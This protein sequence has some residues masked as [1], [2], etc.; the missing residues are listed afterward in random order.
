MAGCTGRC[1]RCRPTTGS[2]DEMAVVRH[3]DQCVG[4]F[5]TPVNPLSFGEKVNAS[6]VIDVGGTLKAH[7]SLRRPTA[8]G[9]GRRWRIADRRRSTIGQLCSWSLRRDRR[10][11]GPDRDRRRHDEVRCSPVATEERP[12][13]QESS[14]R[15]S[16]WSG[17][18][19]RKSTASRLDVL[20]HRDGGGAALGRFLRSSS[21]V[22]VAASS[23]DGGLTWR[24]HLC[25]LTWPPRASI[26]SAVLGPKLLVGRLEELLDHRRKPTL[27]RHPLHLR[28]G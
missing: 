17:A 26:R 12:G 7:G 19:P 2:P 25:R 20:G 4:L 10:D 14:H 16:E 6:N 27:E 9:R 5:R 3:R 24:I 22:S 28:R 21:L 1:D 18:D 8:A 11:S 15:A 13:G 23:D